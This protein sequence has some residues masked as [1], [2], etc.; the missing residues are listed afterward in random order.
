MASPIPVGAFHASRQSLANT[1]D[2]QEVAHNTAQMDRALAQATALVEGELHRGFFPWYGTRYFNWPDMDNPLS[3]RIRLDDNDLI[4]LSAVS[5]GGT[6]LTASS[7]VMYPTTGPPFTSIETSF[8]GSDVFQSGDT[9]QAAIALT[10]FWGYSRTVRTVAT[11]V[12]TITDTATSL[13]VSDSSGLGV[14]NVILIDAEYMVVR[15]IG[16]ATTGQTLQTPLTAS[17][18]GTSVVV[19]TGTAFHV[20]EMITIDAEQMLVQDIASNT[21][22]VK[23]AFNG[24]VLA[25]HTGSTIYAPRTLTVDRAAC[26]SAEGDYPGQLYPDIDLYPDATSTSTTH[27]NGVNV[28]LHVIPAPVEA[29]CLAEAGWLYSQTAGG[30]QVASNNSLA[31]LRMSARRAVGRKGRQRAI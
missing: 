7:I 12:G 16:T 25:T 6:A 27:T 8:A 21:L 30:W 22:L 9:W 5:A 18:A 14:G 10:G 15:R 17:A 4:S 2:F 26:V 11:L 23:R 3:Y 13:V 28:Q 1:L 19:T 29:L 31:D 24:T 20:G